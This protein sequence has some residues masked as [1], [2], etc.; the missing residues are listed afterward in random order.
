MGRNGRGNAGKKKGR[1]SRLGA[2]FGPVNSSYFIF[3]TNLNYEFAS[4]L[5]DTNSNC[6]NW[7]TCTKIVGVLYFIGKYFQTQCMFENSFY[8][9]GLNMHYLNNSLIKLGFIK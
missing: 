8:A 2:L 7:E 4:G 1:G 9:N 6:K 5:N 3:L